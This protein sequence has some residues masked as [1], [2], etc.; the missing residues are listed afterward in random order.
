MSIRCLLPCDG[1]ADPIRLL[2]PLIVLETSLNNWGRSTSRWPW[3]ICK[4]DNYSRHATQMQRAAEDKKTKTREFGQ[5][6]AKHGKDLKREEEKLGTE[7]GLWLTAS[8]M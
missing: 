2:I 1:P 8:G 6:H 7:A 4:Q 3:L 5:I